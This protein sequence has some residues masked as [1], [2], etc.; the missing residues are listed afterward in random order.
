[1]FDNSHAT[2]YTW[3]VA[4]YMKKKQTNILTRIF[5]SFP[6]SFHPFLFILTQYLYAILTMIPVIFYYNSF[7]IH[8]A[9]IIF[10]VMLSVFNGA[11]YYIE[12][13]SHR[14]RIELDRLEKQAS[15]L[16]PDL[17]ATDLGSAMS[18]PPNLS[19]PALKSSNSSLSL[20]DDFGDECPITVATTKLETAPSDKKN[21]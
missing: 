20:A 18:L 16:S 5:L 11:D 10:L 19:S 15:I 14:Y 17:T 2:S 21:Q 7:Y 3:L 12:V 1:M 8:T 6:D 13:F 9:F 4:D